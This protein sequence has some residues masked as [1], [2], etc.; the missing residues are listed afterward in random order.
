MLSPFQTV[1]EARPSCVPMTSVHGADL[2]SSDVR[3]LSNGTYHVRVN[4]GGDYSR[5]K[6]PLITRW[7]EDATRCNGGAFWRYRRPRNPP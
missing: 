7:R 6:N 5:W 1:S 2:R 3:L 4:S